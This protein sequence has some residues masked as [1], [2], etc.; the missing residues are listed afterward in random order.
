MDEEQYRQI[1][2]RHGIGS[3]IVVLSPAFLLVLFFNFHDVLVNPA[4]AYNIVCLT[5]HDPQ[6]QFGQQMLHFVLPK[7]SNH[8][9]AISIFGQ[10]NPIYS[11]RRD[12]VMADMA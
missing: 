4:G 1:E 7:L 6:V 10:I 9:A 3:L 8:C 2:K 12:D 11:A 5:S